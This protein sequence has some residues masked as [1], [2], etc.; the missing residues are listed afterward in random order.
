[1]G[2]D[3][4]TI[5]VPLDQYIFDTLNKMAAQPGSTTDISKI[6]PQ[7]QTSKGIM[8]G[9]PLSLPISIIERHPC[10]ET[11][12]RFQTASTQDDTR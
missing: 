4:S 10:V 5:L 6:D 1:M 8:M 11:A 2:R 12:A 3:G 9:Y 7:L